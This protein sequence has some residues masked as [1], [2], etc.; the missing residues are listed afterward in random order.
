L[1]IA[2]DFVSRRMFKSGHSFVLNLALP[3]AEMNR[4]ERSPLG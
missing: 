4:K 2:A 1:G 3:S